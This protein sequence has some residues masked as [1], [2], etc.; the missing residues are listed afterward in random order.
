MVRASRQYL[1]PREVAEEVGFGIQKVR[2]LCES[3]R[4]PAINTT[5][6]NRPRW[7]IRR[8]DLEQFL[9]PNNHAV[10]RCEVKTLRPR[11]DRDVPKV[12]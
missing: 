3:G 6:A 8:I 1:T 11:I 9:S 12:F 2:M 7:L 10:E 5:T 4:L